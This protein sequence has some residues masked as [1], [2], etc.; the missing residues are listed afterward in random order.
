MNPYLYRNPL[1]FPGEFFGH[2]HDRSLAAG[3]RRAAQAPVVKIRGV[4]E[5]LQ[6]TTHWNLTT[7]PVITH[8]QELQIQCRHLHRNAPVDHVVVKIQWSQALGELHLGQIEL[9][10]VPRQVHNLRGL[11][12]AENHR[13]VSFE[14]VTGQVYDVEVHVSERGWDWTG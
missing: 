12:R 9:E 8:I 13:R 3:K 1:Q 2:L 11:V 4:V 10:Q 7:Q 14:H 6:L 5:A